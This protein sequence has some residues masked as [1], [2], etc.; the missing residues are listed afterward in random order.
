ML[1]VLENGADTSQEGL[2]WG[3][4]WR[5][6]RR[7]QANSDAGLRGSKD[8]K[9]KMPFPDILYAQGQELHAL[10]TLRRLGPYPSRT[11]SL[12]G[13]SRDESYQTIDLILINHS[14]NN[15]NGHQ[16]TNG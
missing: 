4:Q 13:D 8:E 11:W 1:S 14:K 2:A 6:S 9:E 3:H 16:W 10:E 5:D 7:G 12:V 15:L